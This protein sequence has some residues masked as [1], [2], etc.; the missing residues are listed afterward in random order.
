MHEVKDG[1]LEVASL[2]FATMP[3]F[4]DVKN[5][6]CC[7]GSPSWRRYLLSSQIRMKVASSL[8]EEGRE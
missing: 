2:S 1:V 4:I 5:R 7:E 6:S 3:F 8:A